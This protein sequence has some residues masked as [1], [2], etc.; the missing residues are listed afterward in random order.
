MEGQFFT[1]SRGHQETFTSKLIPCDMKWAP[2][3]SGELSNVATYLSPFANVCQ[4]NKSTLF[5]SIGGLDATWQPWDYQ[6]QLAMAKKV[7][8][9]KKQLW[10]PNGKE[11]GKVTKF[12]ATNKSQQEYVP[13][14]RKYVD[15]MRPDPLHNAKQRLAAVVHN[16]SYCS[17]AV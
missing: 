3:F 12:I 8:D 6:Q 2:S 1:T 9:F 7:E 5:G 10:D 14:L 17:Y 13:P 11:R 16:L 4:G 15:C